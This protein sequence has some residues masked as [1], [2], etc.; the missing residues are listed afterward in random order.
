M[1]Y[2]FLSVTIPFFPLLSLSPL[3][4]ITHN[5]K[6][7]EPKAPRIAIRVYK[8][9]TFAVVA[10]LRIQWWWKEPAMEGCCTTRCRS[11]SSVRCIASTPFCRVRSSRSSI[12]PRS[13]LISIAR[14]ARSC[15]PRSLLP[16]SNRTTCRSMAISASRFG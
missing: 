15:S 7:K 10:R 9:F 4:I 14:S 1:R 11:P 3:P 16:I 8:P 5:P 2:L 6:E 12:W 13:P